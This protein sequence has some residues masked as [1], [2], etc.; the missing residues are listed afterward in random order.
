MQCHNL[1]ASHILELILWLLELEVCLFMS[2]QVMTIQNISGHS[3]SLTILSAI[4]IS[5]IHR[6]GKLITFVLDGITSSTFLINKFH[7][8]SNFISAKKY[9]YDYYYDVRIRNASGMLL[10]YNC[11]GQSMGKYHTCF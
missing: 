3:S 9:I 10:H 2:L 7:E 11:S 5:R 1:N 8:L 6:Q 4:I